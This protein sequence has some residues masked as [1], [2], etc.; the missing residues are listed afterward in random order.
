MPIEWSLTVTPCTFLTEHIFYK[1]GDHLQ[2]CFFDILRKSC[3]NH[4]TFSTNTTEEKLKLCFEYFITLMLSGF[5]YGHCL[6]N[7][8]CFYRLAKSY[9]LGEIPSLKDRITVVRQLWDL[10][11][12]VLVSLTTHYLHPC[13]CMWVW[14]E[15]I[16][17]TDCFEKFQS[18]LGEGGE[19]W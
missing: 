16:W 13:M 9:V 6:M 18:I 12:D 11:G 5:S 2:I 15:Q 14:H 8:C 10:T 3:R 7:I 4:P 17:I 1:Y 19:G